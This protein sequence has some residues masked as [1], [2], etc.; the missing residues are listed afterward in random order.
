MAKKWESKRLY[1]HPAQ[2]QKGT[3]GRIVLYDSGIYGLMVGA[4]HMS[5][6][7]DWAAR[8]HAEEGEP[9]EIKYLLS[10]DEETWA[11]FK[12]VCALKRLKIKDALAQA[13]QK[14]IEEKKGERK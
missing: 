14:I 13:I 2:H 7:Q 3:Y 11:Q 5:C 12:S 10:V 6:P 9:E 1:E 4:S 8:I